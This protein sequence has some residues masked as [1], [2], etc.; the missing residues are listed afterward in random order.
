MDE[1]ATD[2]GAA[3][4]TG[5]RR[6][7][8]LLAIAVFVYAVDLGSK[9]LVVEKLEYH[10]PVPVLGTWLELRVVRNSG[11]AFGLGGAMTLVFT[12]IAAAVAVAIVRLAR[13]L[14]SAPWA[15]ALGLLLGGALGNL[16]DRVFRAPGG[17]RGAVVDFLAVRDFSVMNLADWAIVG[18]GVLIVYCSFRGWELGGAGGTTGGASAGAARP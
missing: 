1:T 6:T 11:A 12:L 2:E 18:G 3:V 4:S 5:R 17:L 8:L 9:L 10:A 13:R 15:I 16:T 14:H 7:P